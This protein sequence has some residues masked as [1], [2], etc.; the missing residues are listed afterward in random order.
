MMKQNH[1]APAGQGVN[2]LK[3]I[4]KQIM[5]CHW[6]SCFSVL[7]LKL[8]VRQSLILILTGF[9]RYVVD[10]QRPSG[11]GRSSTPKPAPQPAA[12]AAAAAAAAPDVSG[13][14]AT[15]ATAAGACA[16]LP[17]ASG[18]SDAGAFSD[19]GPE[20]SRSRRCK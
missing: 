14:A 15:L 1:V 12:S 16:R 3:L 17:C 13:A 2:V 8:N 6:N 4:T 10:H 20:V 18:R 5:M 9:S 19:A 11:V 7:Q